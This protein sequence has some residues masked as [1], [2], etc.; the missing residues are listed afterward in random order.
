MDEMLKEAQRLLKQGWAVQWLGHASKVPIATGWAQ[1]PVMT[2]AE[3]RASYRPGYNLGFR[4]GKW[5]VVNGQELV[6]LDVDIRGGPAFAEEAYA[7][8]R[9]LLDGKGFSVESGSIVGRHAMLLVPI[10]TSPNCAA[11]TLRE[12]DV[13]VD[14]TSGRIVKPKS[15]ESRPAWQI[16]LLSTGKNVVLPPSIHPDTNQPYRWILSG[17]KS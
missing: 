1:A 17:R 3:L 11:T 2:A 12:S 7:A 14:K 9:Q 10:G 16:E 6:V 15:P 5:S 13:W 4:P 8:A